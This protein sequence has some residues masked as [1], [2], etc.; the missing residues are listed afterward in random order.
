MNVREASQPAVTAKETEPG[1]L[2]LQG[3]NNGSAW[4]IGEPVPVEP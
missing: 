4:I 2:W 3:R 1:L